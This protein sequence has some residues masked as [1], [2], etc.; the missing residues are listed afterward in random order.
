MHKIILVNQITFPDKV[1]ETE[2]IIGV[3]A[4]TVAVGV[5]TLLCAVTVGFAFFN[6]FGVYSSWLYGPP[7]LYI[8]TLVSGQ[9]KIP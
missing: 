5:T 9:P 2:D 6:T 8:L 1:Y 3:F 4:T 7:I